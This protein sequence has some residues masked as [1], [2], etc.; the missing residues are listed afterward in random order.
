MNSIKKNLFL[1][2][3]FKHREFLSKLLLASFA[4]KAGF[5]VYVG[6]SNSIFRLIKSKS[7]KKRYQ[8][9]RVLPKV[10]ELVFLLI[11]KVT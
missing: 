4:L 1:P 2:I 8:K 7:K 11:R 6:S 5:R 9:T 3:E 10:Q